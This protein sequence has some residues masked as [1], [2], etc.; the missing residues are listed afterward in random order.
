[1]QTPPLIITEIMYHPAPPPAG[2]TNDS[3]NF[4][5][6]ELKNRGGSPLNLIG[7]RFTN[8]IDFTFTATS[9]VT[10][11][12]PGQRAVVVRNRAAFSSRYPAATSIAGEYLGSLDNSGERL[13][14]LGSLLEP[15][16]DFRY[17]NSWYPI[18]D[19]LGFSLV[20][21][22]ENA[23]LA[24]WT[25]QASWRPSGVVNGSPTQSDVPPAAI[26]AV[27]ITEAL[28]HTDLPLLDAIE[29]YNPPGATANIGGW[30]LS[31]DF[32]A[33]KKYRIPPGTTMPPD[34]YR[35]F[36]ETSFNAGLPGSFRL[37]SIGDQAYLFS[38]DASTNLTGYFHGF[39]FG[40]AQNPVAFG[41]YVTSIGAEHFVAQSVNTLGAANA[42]PRVGPVVLNELLFHPPPFGTNNNTLDEYIELRNITSQSVPL[43]DPNA[44]TNTWKLGGGIDYVFPLGLSLPAGGYLLVVN[45]DPVT[46]TTQLAAFR[47]KYGLGAG[48]NLVGPYGSSLDNA[49]EK[50]SLF[51][52]DPPQTLPDP[53]VGYVPYVLVDRVEYAST[54]PWPTNASGN[55]NSLQRLTST[56]YGNDPI[57]WQAAGP[58]P[59]GAN[60]GG[61]SADTDGDGLPDAWEIVN[62]LNPLSAAGDN[63]ALGDPDRDGFGNLQEYTSGTNPR[64]PASVFKIEAVTLLVNQANIQFNAVAGNTYSIL[65]RTNLNTGSWIK[66]QDV[67]AQAA[68][69]LIVVSDPA[70][71]AG[72]R[73]Y[74]RLTTP[75]MP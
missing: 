35:V 55:G 43:F 9:G 52:P 30:F 65:Y 44:A 3:E 67:P 27:L 74:Y 68:T 25:N 22:D 40:A 56:A 54:S 72:D 57:N 23:A 6:I 64:D 53:Y 66:L 38:G 29:I 42:G 2:N 18:T 24:T 31:D 8:G 62:N 1:V 19:G 46:N 12:G 14:L 59:G 49:G 17:E 50:I 21:A 63:G 61:G 15:I 45:F 69:G 7:F 26:P 34:S 41:R 39:D 20:I 37:S 4:E 58:T 70:A 75:Q 10:N 13:A 11:L 28:T 5:Y 32:N 60:P 51:R 73:R 33:P 71:V 16:H 48:V 36:Y 47:S